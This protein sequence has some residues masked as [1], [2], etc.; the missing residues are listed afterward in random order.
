MFI[1]AQGSPP[2]TL[3]VFC[4][5]KIHMRGLSIAIKYGCFSYLFEICLF[6]FLCGPLPPFHFPAKSPDL[7]A[8]LFSI[9]LEVLERSE[10][11]L[12]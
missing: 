1:L 7:V 11:L 2:S 8:Q 6:L 12:H 5:F 10:Q 4:F 9:S 3:S